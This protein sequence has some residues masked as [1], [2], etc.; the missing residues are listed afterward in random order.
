MFSTRRQRPRNRRRGHAKALSLFG[1]GD[2]DYI[3]GAMPSILG[4]LV[5]TFE[6]FA[7]DYADALS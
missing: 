3:T 4:R 1:Q 2:P 6:Q 7:T 5:R